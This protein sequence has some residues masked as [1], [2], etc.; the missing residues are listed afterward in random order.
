VRPHSSA[1]AGQGST[2]IARPSNWPTRSKIE[3]RTHKDQSG[4]IV[5]AS[6]TSRNS[7]SAQPLS[8]YSRLNRLLFRIGSKRSVASA[9]ISVTPLFPGLKRLAAARLT[10]ALELVQQ[11]DPKRFRRMCA[12]M[13]RIVVGVPEV[14]DAAYHPD[15]ELCV[16]SFEL[17]TRR[18]LTSTQLALLV[19]HEA[20]HARIE[21]AGIRYVPERRARIER[22]CLRAELAFAERF[23][24][25]ERDW[26]VSQYS[27]KLA[28][29]MPEFSDEGLIEREAA[30]SR[31]LGVP[32]WFIERVRRVQLERL[33]KHRPP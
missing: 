18:E 25:R 17:L 8:L 10:H 5:I 29:P 2:I 23:S 3:I 27:A 22:A 14:G 24:G 26:Y 7:R 33:K 6:S 1:H 9:T 16:V 20:T 11:R 30:E 32:N 12:D 31:Q 13:P 21:R 4:E 19:V 28:A 15:I